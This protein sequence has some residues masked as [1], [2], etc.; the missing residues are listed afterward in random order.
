M[1]LYPLPIFSSLTAF[2]VLD[3]WLWYAVRKRVKSVRHARFWRLFIAIAMLP[4]ALF[5]FATIAAFH[6]M[7]DLSSHIPAAVGAYV[8]IWNFIIALPF[9]AAICVLAIGGK[10]LAVGREFR[11]RLKREKL[12]IPAPATEE[13][14]FSRRNFLTAAAVTLPPLA[15][16]SLTGA[17]VAQM[18]NFRIKPYDLK[19]PGWP[20]ELDGFTITLVA[21]VH[22]GIFSTERMLNEIADRANSLRSDL[23]LLGGDLVNLSHKDLPSALDMVMKLDAR[24]GVYMVQ[25]NHDVVQPA[26]E[27]NSICR[28]RGVNLLVD[29]IA[30]LSPNGIPIQILGTRWPKYPGDMEVSIAEVASQ[31]DPLAFPILLAHHPHSFDEANIRG[32]PLILSGHTHGGQIMLTKNIGGGPLRFKY[33]TGIYQKPG[34]TL[35][36]SNGVGNWFPFRVNAPAEIN[37]ITLH[38]ADSV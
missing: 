6:R 1:N 7:A 15:A 26:A 13:S 22:A 31:R 18:G 25:G 20:A 30:S 16:V 2:F 37:Q 12:P 33:W 36:V 4:P 9:A 5:T 38:P 8:Y 23:M 34:S 21:D 32:I 24:Y 3:I 17:S 19:L 28:R 35:L 29:Q 11:R 10:L 27:F 14:L